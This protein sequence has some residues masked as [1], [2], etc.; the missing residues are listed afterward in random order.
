[1]VSFQEM[2]EGIDIII[3]IRRKVYAQ[4]AQRD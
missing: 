2:K 3:E 1:M 4:N